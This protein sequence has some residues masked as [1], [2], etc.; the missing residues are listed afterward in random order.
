MAHMLKAPEVLLNHKPALAFLS[1]L[2]CAEFHWG[3]IPRP[4]AWHWLGIRR[5]NDLYVKNCMRDLFT[6]LSQFFLLVIYKTSL[7]MTP[8][9]HQAQYV[10]HQEHMELNKGL[11]LC[12]AIWVSMDLAEIA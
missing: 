7:C 11:T 2:T 8:R 5:R 4:I 9:Q 1:G 12:I 3:S 6:G 10:W